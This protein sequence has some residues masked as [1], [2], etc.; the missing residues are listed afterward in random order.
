MLIQWLKWNVGKRKGTFRSPL[1]REVE[2]DI[3]T[4]CSGLPSC[5]KECTYRHLRGLGHELSLPLADKILT[6]LAELNLRR[7]IFSGGGGG[8]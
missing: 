7:G 4:S 3:T 8:A 2:I 5:Q 6:Q 1:V